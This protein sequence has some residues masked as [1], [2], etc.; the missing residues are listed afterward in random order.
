M[1]GAGRSSDRS[2]CVEGTGQLGNPACHDRHW[3]RA[4]VRFWFRAYT[5]SD[6]H[7][8]VGGIIQPTLERYRV[9]SLAEPEVDRA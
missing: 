7:G 5:A 3:L 9:G 1:M 2:C 4:K 8:A 6:P